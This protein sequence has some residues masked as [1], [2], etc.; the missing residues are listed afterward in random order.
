VRNL[1]DTAV[2]RIAAVPRSR[3]Y[4]GGVVILLLA[5]HSALVAYSG[6]VHSPTVDEPAHLA[7]G[8]CHWRL[9]EF[10]LYSVNPPLVRMV[11]ALPVLAAGVKTDWSRL[12]QDPANRPEFVVGSDFIAA[13]RERSLFLVMVARWACI[14]FSWLGGV[15]CYLWTRRL[16]GSL[17]GFLAATLWCFSPNILAPAS[18]ITPDLAAT[19]L[20]ITAC[21]LFWRWLRHPNYEQVI[22]TGIVL[23]LAEL[24]KFT[25]LIFYPLW[26]VTWFIYTLSQQGLRKPKGWLREGGM[27]AGMFCLSVVVINAGYGFEDSFRPIGKYPF[28]SRLFRGAD[29]RPESVNALGSRFADSCLAAIPIPLPANF[30]Q[31]IDSQ[32]L[33]FERGL[34][35]Y[36]RGEWSSHGW[37]YYYLYALAI[38]V[39]LGTWC[40]MALAIATTVFGR[41]CS[42]SWRDEMVVL[43]PFVVIL[44]FVSSQTGFSVHSRYVIPA[45]PFL[46]VWTSKVARVFDM[47]PF[48]KKRWIMATMVALALIWSVSS[49]LGYYPHSLS[50]FNELVGGPTN[51]HYHLLDSNIAW[52]Q[53][54]FFLKRW[55]DDHPDARPFHLAYYGLMDPRLAGIEFT[56]PPVCPAAGR[57]KAGASTAQMGPLPGW[58]AIDVNHLHGAKISTA[59]GKGGWVRTATDDCDLT[60]FQHFQ[61]VAMAGYSI[62]IY[63]I[64]IDDA[65][66]VRKELELPGLPEDWP[67]RE[68]ESRTRVREIE[69]LK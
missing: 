44:I 61:P 13:N 56:A 42:A 57:P 68:K 67:S 48:T 3:R 49:S 8:N 66:R 65:N 59:D 14:P 30:V 26:I 22:L 32:R 5:V 40:L 41:G 69:S 23:G 28:R 34:P 39:P 21:Y 62:Y 29:S 51:G 54:L 38:K 50:Y 63:H 45:L 6:Y 58:Y 37:W 10:G 33:D 53:D 20:S 46:F 47:R 9:G 25:L 18:L 43:L 60:Y 64:T 36:L 35:S 17:A 16:Y 24:T 1:T 31:G 52:G 12:R 7:A 2:S 15:V 55:Y 27:L 4:A 19:A 11:A